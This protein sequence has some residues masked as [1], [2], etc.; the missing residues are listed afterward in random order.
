MHVD[1]KFESYKLIIKPTGFVGFDGDT[2]EKGDNLNRK[3]KRE[4]KRRWRNVYVNLVSVEGSNRMISD[5][6][7]SNNV[8]KKTTI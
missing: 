8:A 2:G 5:P 4:T 6:N 3:K 1:H 7:K